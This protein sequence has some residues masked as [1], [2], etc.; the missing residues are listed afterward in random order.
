[1]RHKISLFPYSYLKCIFNSC[2]DKR[3]PYFNKRS[4][5][6]SEN[7]QHLY[8]AFLNIFTNQSA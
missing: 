4:S 6:E 8:T 1:M 3:K 5:C 7:N 2:A